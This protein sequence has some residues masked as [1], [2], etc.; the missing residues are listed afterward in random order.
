MVMFEDDARKKL[1]SHLDFEVPENGDAKDSVTLP[2]DAASDGLGQKLNNEDTS[3]HSNVEAVSNS[4]IGP[5]L[6]LNGS[7]Q[8][9]DTDDFFDNIQ[10]PKETLSEQASRVES[11]DSV[12]EH[13]GEEQ[14]GGDEQGSS[15]D[16][17]TEDAIQ[18]ALVVG[19]FQKA[20][21]HCIR[22][23]RTADALILAFVS[24]TTLWEKT[25]NDYI[26]RSHRTYLKVFVNV[27]DISLRF[28]DSM[29]FG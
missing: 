11:L 21:D 9:D 18:K 20:V 22:A 26:K 14:F 24:G 25:R 6:S 3:S 19:D 12:S 4:S 10:T 16:A 23:N 27:C 29:R 8:V 5:S 1:L 28:I 7:F 17:E 15:I 13:A 2:E